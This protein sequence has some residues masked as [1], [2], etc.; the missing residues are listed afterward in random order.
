MH[1][2]NGDACEIGSEHSTVRTDADDVRAALAA[3]GPVHGVVFVHGVDARLGGADPVGIDALQFMLV[4]TQCL[5][6]LPVEQRPRAYV[7]TRGAFSLSDVDAP[8]EPAQTALC[9]FARVA[10]NELDGLQFSAVDMPV[11]ATDQDIEATMLELIC[12]APEDQVAIRRGQ[13]F[14]SRLTVRP[15]LSEPSLQAVPLAGRAVELRRVAAAGETG[16][17]AGS[18]RLVESEAARAPL[19]DGDVELKI[20]SMLPTGPMRHAWDADDVAHGYVEVLASVVRIGAGV[21]DLRVGQRVYGLAP[22]RFASHIRGPRDAFHLV[23]LAD[24][25]D[26]KQSETLLGRGVMAALAECLADQ[27][28]LRRD[29]CV[30]IQADALGL[31]LDAALRARGIDTVLLGCPDASASQDD[32]CIAPLLDAATLAGIEEAVAA[33]TGGQGFAAFAGPMQTWEQHYGWRA[34]AAGGVLIDTGCATGS[35]AVPPAASAIVRADLAVLTR[36]DEGFVAALE[37][38]VARLG[39]ERGERGEGGE[40]GE[41]GGA[42][43]PLPRVSIAELVRSKTAPFGGAAATIVSFDDDAVALPVQLHEAVEF[44][45]EAV[46]L[47]TGGFGGFGQKT[48]Q[49]LFDHGARRLLLA[50]RTGANTPEREAFVEQLRRRGAEVMAVAC[51]LSNEDDVKR[52]FAT[53]RDTGLPLRGIFHAAAVIID[54]PVAEV[55]LR[56]QAEVLRSKAESARLLHEYSRSMPLDYFV[57]YSSVASEVGSSY[58]SS[59]V[60]ANSFL[61]G[62]AWHRR[63]L[64]LPATSINWGAIEDVGVITLDD[65]LGQFMRYTGLRGMH[66]AEALD[67]LERALA[68]GLTQLGIMLI[69]TWAEWGR[70]ETLG[71]KSPRLAELVASDAVADNSAGDLLRAELAALPAS[72]RLVALAERVSALVA[73]LLDISGQSIALD[74]PIADLGIDSLMATEIQLSLREELDIMISVLELSDGATIRTVVNDA[75]N[76]WGLGDNDAP[77][78]A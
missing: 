33:H 55:D 10:L 18:V 8:V 50:G 4:I 14:Y 76:D 2:R 70:Y 62:L 45:P 52:L 42:R 7:L 47:V 23:A 68:R 38:V 43:P 67:W 66:S 56:E 20:A 34:L 32:A 15:W 65:K 35:F 37:R 28:D 13:R 64:G 19:R 75:L 51:D 6:A 46:Y 41:G 3:A 53:L 72:E 61:D 5:A 60:S 29:A 58:Q 48:A 77:A 1:L 39:G 27:A 40:G 9:G 57:L 71:A 21:S 69:S 24:D 36:R 16:R 63:A 11:D 73:R 44:D 22:A 59:Y 25:T 74:R 12:D 17:T 49:W 78:A 30:L 54:S 31:A 26:D